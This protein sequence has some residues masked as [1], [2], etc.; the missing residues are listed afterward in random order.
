MYWRDAW[1]GR[2]CPDTHFMYTVFW[3]L[4]PSR[5]SRLQRLIEFFIDDI[6]LVP[7][8]V[9]PTTWVRTDDDDSVR[10]LRANSVQFPSWSLQENWWM[11][12]EL[13]SSSCRKLSYP[14][15]P[16]AIGQK[17]S[18]LHSTSKSYTANS[19]TFFNTVQL[20]APNVSPVILTNEALPHYMKRCCERRRLFGQW[21]CCV[22]LVHDEPARV[23]KQLSFV[24]SWCVV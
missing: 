2:S 11:F 8:V 14:R 20:P 3:R 13:R 12:N 24:M 23:I 5:R 9:G 6:R 22:Y 15:N 18:W 4:P 21:L 16:A 10:T 17:T 19:S 1:H 7:I